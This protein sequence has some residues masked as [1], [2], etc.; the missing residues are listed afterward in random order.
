LVEQLNIYVTANGHL[1]IYFFKFSIVFTQV[2]LCISAPSLVFADVVVMPNGDESRK[3]FTGYI[4]ANANSS[5]VMDQLASNGLP[6]AISDCSMM[7]ASNVAGQKV[8][9][10]NDQLCE[11]MVKPPGKELTNCTNSLLQQ[12]SEVFIFSTKMANMAAEAVMQGHFSNI[13]EF[14]IDNIDKCTSS[15]QQV[16]SLRCFFI[17]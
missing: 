4:R 8:A 14:H 12:P 1:F 11:F 7:A 13:I 16:C 17:D 9:F 15:A 5:S 6:A 3:S 2:T 10:S